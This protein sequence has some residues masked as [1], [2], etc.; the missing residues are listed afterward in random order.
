[1]K[2]FTDAQKECKKDGG[3]MLQLHTK[4]E[5]GL[6]AKALASLKMKYSW[7]DLTV[8]NCRFF[9]LSFFFVKHYI[10]S[11]FAYSKTYSMI[12]SE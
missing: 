6:A 8:G 2:K 12:F 7:M 9:L 4:A 1:M 11:Q 10:S 3:S 5:N